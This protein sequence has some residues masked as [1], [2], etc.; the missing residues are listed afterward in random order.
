MAI[1]IHVLTGSIKGQELLLP[2]EGTF[3]LG[4]GQGDEVAFKEGATDPIA[5]LTIRGDEVTIRDFKT[6]S[7]VFVNRRRVESTSVKEGDQ[8]RIGKTRFMLVRVTKYSPLHKAAKARAAGKAAADAE[9]GSTDAKAI[10]VAAPPPPPPAV[11]PARARPTARRKPGE[12]ALF[13][14][15]EETALSDVLRC[16]CGRQESGVINL[17]RPGDL[18]AI[19]ISKGRIADAFMT[20]SPVPNA[21]RALCRLLRWKTGEYA[22]QPGEARPVAPVF[23]EPLEELL[24]HAEMERV[25]ME[26]LEPALPPMTTKLT[27]AKLP[28][29]GLKKLTPPEMFILGLVRLH[30][31]VQEVIDRHPE[32]DLVVCKHLVSLLRRGVLC[33]A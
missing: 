5:T 31:T 20:S 21:K 26:A 13:G 18:G 29:G 12:P 15:L 16:V 32:T 17:S 1:A 2:E 23:D 27:V 4:Q 30:G 11:V 33:V 28:P 7:G 10:P 25:E 8:V 14:N 3:P 24:R 22:F 19:Q 6:S 9:V